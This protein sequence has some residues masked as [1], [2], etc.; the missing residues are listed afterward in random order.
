MAVVG[1][2]AGKWKGKE[3][4]SLI[5]L[6]RPSAAMCPEL[7]AKHAGL[8]VYDWEGADTQGDIDANP[9]WQPAKADEWNKVRLLSHA[10]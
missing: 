5:R 1:G 3:R 4:Q 6:W 2:T 9:R 7:A 10:A 8:A